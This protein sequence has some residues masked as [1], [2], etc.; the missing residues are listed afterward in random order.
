LT[1]E[2]ED[3]I[4]KLGWALVAG[5][6]GFSRWLRPGKSFLLF[7]SVQFLFPF[8]VFCFV[9]FNTNLLI[10]FAGFELVT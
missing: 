6:L 8:S 4:G 10:C 1:E 2:E 9:I 7:F 3:R 5:L